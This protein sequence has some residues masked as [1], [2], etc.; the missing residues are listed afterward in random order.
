[1]ATVRLRAADHFGDVLLCF[2]RE[3][4]QAL[5]VIDN[6]TARKIGDPEAGKN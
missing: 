1:V 6:E 3:A 5:S 2:R 4:Y